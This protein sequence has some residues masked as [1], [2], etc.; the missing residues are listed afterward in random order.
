MISK[1]N[2]KVTRFRAFWDSF[3]SVIHMNA[4]LAPID[5]FNYLKTLLDGLAT[6]AIQGS[7]LS[8]TN[9]EA[10]IGI[11]KD[12][13]GKKQQ[14]VSSHM[15]NLLKTPPCDDKTY[16]L[17]SVYDKIYTKIRGLESLGVRMEQYGSFLILIIMLKLPAEVRLQIGRVSV[18]EVWEVEE[19]MKVIKGEVKRERLVTLLK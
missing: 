1:F 10:V 8:A 15:D 6:Q 18:K 17:R 13:F 16:H 7:D 4:E 5:K 19:L 3:N 14:I 2:E 12:H 9:Y 11:L